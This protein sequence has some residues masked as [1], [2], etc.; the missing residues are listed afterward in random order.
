MHVSECCCVTNDPG[1]EWLKEH[2]SL[3]F[4][5]QKSVSSALGSPIGLQSNMAKPPLSRQDREGSFTRLLV[6]SHTCNILS[7]EPL[8]KAAHIMTADF[9]SKAKR[10]KESA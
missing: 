9:P 5:G 6:R 8:N 3:S 10:V 2:I 1:T 4:L 7:H